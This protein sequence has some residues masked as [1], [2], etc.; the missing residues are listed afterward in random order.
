VEV[1]AKAEDAGETLVEALDREEQIDRL[2]E[3]Y[4]SRNPSAAGR[5]KPVLL[6]MTCR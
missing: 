5:P 1:V 6:R 3:K 2:G 4:K